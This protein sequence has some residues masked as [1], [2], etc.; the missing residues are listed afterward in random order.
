MLKSTAGTWVNYLTTAIFQV[1]FARRFGSSVDAS[2]YA[3]TFN[4]AVALAAIFV[5]TAQSIYIPRMLSP[6]DELLT[7]VFGRMLKLTLVALVLFGGLAAAASLLH[8]VIAPTLN[9]PSTHF[10]ELIRL[11]AVYGF[12]QVLVGQLAAVSWARG[13]R[14]VP[15]VSPAIPSIVASV[16]LLVGHAATTATLYELLTA[17]SLLQIIVLTGAGERGLKFSGERLESGGKLT[18]AWFATFALIQLIVPFELFIAAHSSASGGANFNYAYRSIAVAQAL[19]V[20]GVMSAALPDWSSYARRNARAMLERSIAQTL[21]VA[22]L[23][24]C[25]AAAIGLVA[26]NTLVR[27]AFQ[28]G[29]FT[30]HDTR[31]VSEIIVAALVGF[32]A[33]GVMLVLSPALLAQRRSRLAIGLAVGRTAAVIA[34]VSILG[35]TMGPVGVALGYSGASLIVVVAQLLLICREGMLTRRQSRLARSTALIALC[36]GAAAAATLP[37]HAPSLLRAIVVIT[38]FASLIVAL[39]DRLPRLRVPM[40]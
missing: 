34:L 11:T 37:L 33:E 29:A 25:L 8:P 6:N 18:I 17:G 16:P 14:F 39:R 3:L 9:H 24:L 23:A 1:L 2:A 5:G 38:V 21:S 22:A 27:I 32:V 20:G 19:I 30:A 10:V 4:I 31:I 7:A 36:T 12:S 40:S 13:S 26:S 28:R 15:A 35:L